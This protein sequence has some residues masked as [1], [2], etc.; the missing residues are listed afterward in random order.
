MK[1]RHALITA[2]VNQIPVGKVRSYGSVASEAGLV[3]GARQV[4]VSCCKRSGPSMAP[5]GQC[6]AAYFFNGTRC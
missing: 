3:N 4:M 1:E 2:V 5:G 6:A